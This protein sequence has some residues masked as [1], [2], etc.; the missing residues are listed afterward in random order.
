MGIHE[1]KEREKEHR[2]EEILDAAQ[3]VFFEKGLLLATMD[4]IAETAELSKGTLYLYY[5]SKEDLYLTVMMRGMQLLYEMFAEVVKTTDSVP[6]I[7]FHFGEAYLEYFNRHRNYFR[8]MHFLQT[9]QFHK[10]VSDEMKQSCNV[11]N[12]HIWDLVNGVIQR[13]IEEGSLRADLNPVEVSIIIWSSATALMLRID[14]N[15]DIWK[16]RF[17]IDLLRT[18]KL[19][20][21]LLFEAIFTEKGKSELATIANT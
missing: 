8:M 15:Y 10:Q 9:P 14:S 13:G 19:S 18:L 16:E 7:L 21:N 17:Q 3:R 1:R 4:E 20:N 6:K 11:L 5:K 2:R 12:Q